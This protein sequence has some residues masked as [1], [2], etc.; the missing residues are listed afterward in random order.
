MC[1]RLHRIWHLH[2]F[3][4]M[5]SAKAGNHLVSCKPTTYMSAGVLAIIAV[6]VI[7]VGVAGAF[8]VRSLFQIRDQMAKA[9][10]GYS[11][12]ELSD[13]HQTMEAGM[14]PEESSPRHSP[15]AGRSGSPTRGRTDEK[16]H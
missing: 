13:P 11:T 7:L 4:L 3:A 15:M 12:V 9:K 2:K 10:A 1:M 5:L 16:Q 8:G 14:L 6:G